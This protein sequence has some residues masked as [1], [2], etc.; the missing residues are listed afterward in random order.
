MRKIIPILAAALGLLALASP[1]SAQDTPKGFKFCGWQDFETGG[2]TYDDPEP[3]AYLA[4][5]ARKMTCRIARRNYKKVEYEE[6][7][8]YRSR[9]PGYRC[10]EVESRHEYS[11]VQCTKRERPRV[12]F[13]WQTGV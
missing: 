3:G 6:S 12:A 9:L 8:P 5:Y 1:A 11:D 10:R 4:L 7:P 13:R 2:W